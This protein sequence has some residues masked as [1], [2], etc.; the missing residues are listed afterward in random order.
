MRAELEAFGLGSYEARALEH[1]LTQGERTGPDLARETG[2]PFGRIYGTLHA[3][4]ERGLAI[5]RGGR[6]RHFAPAPAPTVAGRLLG[7]AKRRLQESE[8][9]ADL[10][11]AS[12]ERS[13]AQ[14]VPRHLPGTAGYGVRLGEDAAR[15]LLVE[16]THEARDTVA[17]F[18]ALPAIRDQD[19]ALFDAFRQAVARGVRTRV[20]LREADVEYLL[21]SPY[22]GP[23]LDAL[24]P[25]LGE[26]LQVRLSRTDTTPFSV[27]DGRRAMLG[28]RNPLEEGSY[29]AVVHLEDPDF[30]SRLEKRFS[31]LWAAA[32]L[33]RG[34]L[35]RV[36]KRLQ[37]D[38]RGAASRIL[39]AAVR[40]RGATPRRT[41]PS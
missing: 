1:L 22:L 30:A 9:Q 41:T 11:A 15:G 10:Q 8:R 29:L 4:V 37:S 18:L 17:A 21:D 2:I 35:Q 32:E 13:I 20:L 26:A 31:A 23:V 36:L 24:L 28:V 25:H 5:D 7:A 19:L 14:I 33:D 3:L 12:L 16:A 39:A 38:K 40:R 27:L 6:P 34:V